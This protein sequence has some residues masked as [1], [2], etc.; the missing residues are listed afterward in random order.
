MSMKHY[1]FTTHA[2]IRCQ[3]RGIPLPVVEFVI[4]NGDSARTHNDWKFYVNKSKLNSIK[5]E[6][7]E[8]IAK[9]DQHILKTAVIL[10]GN[11]IITCMKKKPKKLKWN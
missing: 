3:Q 1:N 6:H 10:N 8:F 4:E 9:F 7:S 2:K 5:R 11:N